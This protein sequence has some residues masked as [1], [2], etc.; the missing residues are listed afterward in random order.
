MR[1][2]IIYC[3][4]AYCYDFKG[5]VGLDLLDWL[6]WLHR[7]RLVELVE[8]VELVGLVVLVGLVELVE[9]AGGHMVFLDCTAWSLREV[10]PLQ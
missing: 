6:N 3:K 5:L 1:F 4:Q 10:W 9:L 2:W 8:L 7:S